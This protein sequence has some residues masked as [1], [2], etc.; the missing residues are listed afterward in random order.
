MRIMIAQLAVITLI[1]LGSDNA[2][3]M[4]F[5]EDPV[6]TTVGKV[7]GAQET[8]TATCGWRGIPYAAPPVGELRFR[9]PQ[10][11]PAWEGV[12]DANT[13]GDRCMQKGI[14]DLADPP[15]ESEDCLYLNVWRPAKSGRFPVM[16]WI[17]GG[18]YTGGSGN[19]LGDRLSQAGDVVVV[20]INYRLNIFGFLAHPE[21][22]KADPHNATGGQGSLDQV[23]ALK[24]VQE[25][26]ENFGGDKNNVTI[27]GE[28]AG[29]WSVCTMLATPLARGLFHRAILES[30]GCEISRDL[31]EGYT[32]TR[33]VAAALGCE[34]DDVQCLRALSAEEL[35]AKSP[36]GVMG[37]DYIPH[38]DGY[39]LTDTPLSMIRA[40][41]FNNVPFLAG[42]NR[43]E[44]GR[45]ESLKPRLYYSMPSGYKKRVIS[46]YDFSEEE[47]QNLVELYP[48]D[49]FGGRPVNAFVQMHADRGLA[50]STYRGLLAASERQPSVYLYRFDYDD[51]RFGKIMG[52]FHGLEIS[53]VFGTLSDIFGVKLFNNRNIGPARELSR[54]VQG[55]WVNFA[56]NGDPN[57]PGLPEWPAFSPGSQKLQV[58]D[59]HTRTESAQLFAERCD[60]WGP[61]FKKGR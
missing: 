8:K 58:L 39:L 5:C 50:C 57:G 30:G 14:M 48:L 33:E 25:N 37:V 51:Q 6:E 16:V 42:S 24:W 53:F 10:P 21:L 41:D 26:I 35:L 47:A 55:Y 9:S 11:A 60:F 27:F 36:Q 46:E 12:L 29:G 45:M 44:F 1:L 4:S 32:F 19:L 28:S 56:R 20:S 61:K 40:G 15:G 23:A 18:G 22:R 43:D 3:A 31:E 52:S 34:F 2:M 59:V 7:R 49:Q 38:H 54:I 13:F 17:H